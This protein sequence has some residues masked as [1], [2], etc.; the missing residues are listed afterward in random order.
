MD[1]ASFEMGHSTSPHHLPDP[2]F[3][4][5]EKEVEEKV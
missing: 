5:T 2:L 3:E 4:K 1:F